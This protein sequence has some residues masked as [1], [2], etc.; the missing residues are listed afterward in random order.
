MAASDTPAH[1]SRS[2]RYRSRYR[3]HVF[4]VDLYFRSKHRLERSGYPHRG[5]AAFVIRT[6][7][8]RSLPVVQIVNCRPQLVSIVTSFARP[9]LYLTEVFN[10]PFLDK[11][12]DLVEQTRNMQ[13][14]TFNYSVI[15]LIV[16]VLSS[17]VIFC[18]LRITI[19]CAQR[20]IHGRRAH[21]QAPEPTSERHTFPKSRVACA[22]TTA[23]H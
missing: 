4:W 5:K 23:R 19:D 9:H 20:T 10:D 17:P 11:L 21:H 1:G 15:K 3:G 12:F 6:T 16:R 7:L 18:R 13:D 14:E 8:V 22:H 2:R